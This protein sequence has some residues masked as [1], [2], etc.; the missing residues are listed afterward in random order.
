MS[1]D[2]SNSR[3][4]ES[5]ERHFQKLEQELIA[6][7]R[8]RNEEAAQVRSLSERTGIVDEG[9]L[10]DL[11]ELGYTDDTVKLL[12]LA[13][14]VQV[15]WA[16]G[17]LSDR[18]RVLI[19]EAARSRGIDEASSAGR[20]LDEWLTSRPSE[21]TLGKAMRIIG[22]MLDARPAAERETSERDLLSYCSAIADA[23]GGLLGFGKVSAHER[24]LIGRITTELTRNH[25]TAA[26]KALSELDKKT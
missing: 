7:L 1:D 8:K 22:A 4:R 17:T 6:K 16:D 13:P 20:Q 12:Y 26:A 11:R 21:D 5:E 23:S 19:L 9:I 18:E 14:L 2:I 25:T 10:T 15:A 24:E 3:R